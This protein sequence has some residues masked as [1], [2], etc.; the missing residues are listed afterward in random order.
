MEL[1][2]GKLRAERLVCNVY[3]AQKRLC[4]GKVC[5][6]AQYP[7]DKLKLGDIIL[8]VGIIKIIC[9][10]H[11]IQSCHGKTL[12][13]GTVIK[14]GTA[15]CH[16]SRADDGVMLGKLPNVP[17]F[18]GEVSW[19]NNNLLAVGHFI[20]ESSAEIKVVGLIRSGCTHII[21]P[22]LI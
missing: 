6:F 2:C 7:W 14:Q 16:M 3:P 19:H 4:F 9:V 11:K 17:E 1:C 10:A 21:I 18:Q 15:P 22:L 8:F 12:F 20:I 5:A 13:V